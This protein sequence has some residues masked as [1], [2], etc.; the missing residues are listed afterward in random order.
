LLFDEKV[1][2]IV[3]DAT[4]IAFETRAGEKFETGEALFPAG[5]TT[6]TPELTS[7][8]TAESNAVLA[9]PPRSSTATLGRAVVATRVL[10]QLS[11]EIL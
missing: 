11:P 8:E 3:D 2:L 10:T 9:P 1:S 4:V 6:G 7:A 5:T